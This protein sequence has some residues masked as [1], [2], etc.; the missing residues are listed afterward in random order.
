M[1]H[2]SAKIELQLPNS[3]AKRAERKGIVIYKEDGKFH[4]KISEYEVDNRKAEIDINITNN[5]ENK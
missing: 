3:V 4:A 1:K 5:G 2:L